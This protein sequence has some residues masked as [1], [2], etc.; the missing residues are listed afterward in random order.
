MSKPDYP[1]SKGEVPG[2]AERIISKL[3][4]MTTKVAMMRKKG[5][6]ES[7]AEPEWIEDEDLTNLGTQSNLSWKNNEALV[8]ENCK[9]L[10][11]KL[12]SKERECV[13]L[14]RTV[15]D[16]KQKMEG[17]E[18]DEN[19]GKSKNNIIADRSQDGEELQQR[20]YDDIV[21]NKWQQNKARDTEKLCYR[22]LNGKYCK[23]GRE[24]W[25]KHKDICRMLI[26]EGCCNNMNCEDG[27]N[28]NGVC[29][30]NK[31]NKCKSKR[32]SKIHLQTVQESYRRKPEKITEKEAND[33][34]QEGYYHLRLGNLPTTMNAREIKSMVDKRIESKA[35]WL[36]GELNGIFVRV[37]KRDD[38]Q[39][40]LNMNGT[41]IGGKILMVGVIY[42]C[43][44][45][46]MCKKPACS[47]IHQMVLES[48]TERC[49]TE[50]CIKKVC[51]YGHRDTIREYDKDT[52]G[53]SPTEKMQ[54]ND[55]DTYDVIDP[56]DFLGEDR[57]HNS[58]MKMEEK[59]F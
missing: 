10:E 46:L 3:P 31:N 16:Y 20:A 9:K 11:S 40:I 50:N 2:D 28:V 43:H 38:A 41:K 7:A 29:D 1:I 36:Q 44:N 4:P 26:E 30:N 59:K 27:H 6:I 37:R 51:S 47:S 23:F 25:F 33:F 55:Q 5:E 42:R 21:N 32:C 45:G 58:R 8:C 18:G 24:C 48:E 14:K 35:V 19:S 34:I 39:T 52:D 49:K 54:D 15:T 22:Y 56:T 57:K 13:G 17:D 53:T 12:H